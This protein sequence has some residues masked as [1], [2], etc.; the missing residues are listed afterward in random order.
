MAKTLTD[1]QQRFVFGGL[2][3]VLVAFGLYLSFGGFDGDDEQGGEEPQAGSSSGIGGPA[4]AA[5]SPIPTTAVEE[6]QVL[7]WLP[8]EEAE[9]KA[10]G[11]TAQA[12]GEAY[13]TIDYTASPEEYYGS[14]EELA[15]K[16][17]AK[18]LAQS[19]GAGAL[20]SE[21]SEKKTVAEGRADVRSIRSFDKTSVVF[22][23]KVQSIIENDEG[24]DED[25]GDYAVTVQK[26]GS[27]WEVYDFQP[28]D[29][30]NVGGK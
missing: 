24:A 12:F 22:V 28:A 4:T 29:A 19:S 13:A 9:L 11:A 7:D 16:D 23:V 17:Y 10:A 5:P 21:M 25:L 2:V 1:R 14:M 27:R 8:F 30:G 3:V 20:W 26:K 15:A 18:S 6:M